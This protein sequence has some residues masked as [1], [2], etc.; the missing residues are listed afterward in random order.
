MESINSTE[1]FITYISEELKLEPDTPVVIA[2]P[3]SE[4]VK[5]IE[6]MKV[7]LLTHSNDFFRYDFRKHVNTKAY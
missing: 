2:S 5:V 1:T 6:F 4:Y 3:N 7:A